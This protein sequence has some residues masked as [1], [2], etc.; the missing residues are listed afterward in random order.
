V[1]VKAT[2]RAEG[3]D[4]E[5]KPRPCGDQV[6]AFVVVPAVSVT[7]APEPGPP[8]PETAEPAGAAES[9]APVDVDDDPYQEVTSEPPDTE[10]AAPEELPA[11]PPEEQPFELRARA[12]PDFCLE[13][14]YEPAEAQR[15]CDDTDVIGLGIEIDAAFHFEEWFLIGVMAGYRYFGSQAA[16][17]GENTEDPTKKSASNHLLLAGLQLRLSWMLEEWVLAVD[18][19]PLG[20]SHQVIVFDNDQYSVN[21]F[22]VTLTLAASYRVGEGS[23]VGVYTELL[24]L[25][26]WVDSNNFRPATISAGVLFGTRL[27]PEPEAEDEE[28][29]ADGDGGEE[30]GGALMRRRLG[31][32]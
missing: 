11:V 1:Q 10:P 7:P 5:G 15:T 4:V 21:E 14:F 12:G 28:P 29:E 8:Q 9:V 2:V 31:D 17:I 6:E 30:G 13:M 23:W 20:I 19:V 24:Q 22:F 3:G 32:I 26:P 18:A 16:P 27:G 25:V